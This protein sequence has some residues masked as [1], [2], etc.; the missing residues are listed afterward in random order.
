VYERELKQIV[1]LLA[2]RNRRGAALTEINL[3]GGHAVPTTGGD[4]LALDAFATRIHALLRLTCER[5]GV[6]EPRLTVSPGRA[7]VARAGV[8]LYRVIAVTRA[9]A[10]H[11]VV[12]VDGGITDRLRRH[13]PQR[14]P[15]RPT[16]SCAAA[17][18]DRRRPT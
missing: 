3:G 14:R 2:R 11:Q 18:H 16:V 13:P 10:D 9:A 5:Y 8:T 17:A 1:D 6:P 7:V 4:G 12:A 15:P